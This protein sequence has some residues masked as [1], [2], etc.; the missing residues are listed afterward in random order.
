MISICTIVSKG[1]SRNNKIA[2][3]IAYRK[4]ADTLMIYMMAA[5][6]PR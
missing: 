3:I 4:I 5:D 1:E 6:M 2:D